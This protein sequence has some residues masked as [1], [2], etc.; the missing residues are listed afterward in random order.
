MNPIDK[1]VN[2]I[3]EELKGNNDK[4]Q[5][6]MNEQQISKNIEKTKD[7][8]IFFQLPLNIIFSII[9][10]A[11]LSIIPD[12]SAF[13]QNFIR[14]TY[15]NHKGE[16]EMVF[17]LLEKIKVENCPLTLDECVSII[18]EF[19]NSQICSLFTKLYQ[20]SQQEVEFDYNYEINQQKDRIDELTD[21]LCD[22]ETDIVKAVNEGKLNSVKYLIEKKGIDPNL[23][24]GKYGSLLILACRSE[25]L[26]IV[27]YLIEKAHA[28]YHTKRWHKYT[29]IQT[30]AKFR[31]E[32]IIKYLIKTC[33]DLDVN[34]VTESEYFTPLHL[35]CSNGSLPIV[36]TLIEEGHAELIRT[37]HNYTYNKFPTEIAVEKGKL[38]IIK[39]FVET[40]K[41]SLESF[42]VNLLELAIKCNQYDIADYLRSHTSFT[43]PRNTRS[44]NQNS[45]VRHPNQTITT[46]NQN[47][48]Y[49]T[50]DNDHQNSTDNQGITVDFDMDMPFSR[51]FI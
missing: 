34:E 23:D 31:C 24:T 7:S 49:N 25:R 42:G 27:Q 14:K 29:L 9:S 11:D 50:S 10:D 41:L 8:D 20:E 5:I 35:A 43:E 48:S 26:N 4:E 30:A 12:C 17:L 18:K 13:I 36:K 40:A 21:T 33:P 45:R 46:S 1:F 38:D 51:S 37:N 44:R 39:Y 47:T 22:I 6:K 16:E 3:I 32:D 19:T 2:N 28:D 15:L